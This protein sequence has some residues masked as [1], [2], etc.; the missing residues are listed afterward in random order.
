MVK[1]RSGNILTEEALNFFIK[2]L[3]EKLFHNLYVYSLNQK[4]FPSHLRVMYL[5]SNFYSHLTKDKPLQSDYI[6]LDVMRHYTRIYIGKDT[7]FDK[8]SKILIP[9]LVGH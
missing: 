1:L 7:I 9:V 5:S 6:D 8:F 4:T 2:Y 3:E